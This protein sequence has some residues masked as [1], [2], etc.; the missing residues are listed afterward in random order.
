MPRSKPSTV[1]EHRMTLGQY[2]RD[3]ISNYAESS[4]LLAVANS[5]KA[6]AWGGS[7][8]ALAYC[9]WW[10]SEH[11]YGWME[12]ASNWVEANLTNP[13]WAQGVA[14]QDTWDEETRAAYREENPTLGD[15][16]FDGPQILWQFLFGENGD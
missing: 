16:I 10:W 11:L 9:L 8:V 5:G 13:P 15:Q 7:A 6:I 1:M 14:A 12:G 4:T 3:L 2:E